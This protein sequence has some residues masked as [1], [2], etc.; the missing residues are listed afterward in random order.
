LT[1]KTKA[2]RPRKRDKPHV[3]LSEELAVSLVAESAFSTDPHALCARYNVSTIT[4]ERWRRKVAEDAR[5]GALVAEKRKALDEVWEC[6]LR[7]TA[8]ELIAAL[9]HHAHL[10]MKADKFDP[11]MVHKLAGA[12]KI[13]NDAAVTRGMVLIGQPA[14]NARKNQAAAKDAGLGDRAPSG[15]VPAGRDGAGSPVAGAPA[16]PAGDP[17]VH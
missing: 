16:T 5:L 7:S 9:A 1:S 15:A 11:D 3:W 6:G 10:A 13:V 4:L 14:P 12:L 2:R 17:P 8:R